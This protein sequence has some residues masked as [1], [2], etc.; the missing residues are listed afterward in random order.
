MEILGREG[1]DTT[2]PG[3]HNADLEASRTRVIEGATWKQQ[4]TIMLIPSA[5]TIPAQVALAL[6][7]L[8][9]PPN[10]GIV[11]WLALGLEVGD[12]YSQ[13]IEQILANP[14]LSKWE[15]LLTVEHD[16]LPPQDGL[17]KLIKRMEAHPEFACIGGLYWTK[18]EGGAPQIW[19]DI[20][21]PVQNYRPQPPVPGQLVEC[22]GTGMGFNLWRLS[23]FK[24]PKIAR[25]WF[26]TKC[27]PA[28][29]VGTQDL[30]FWGE[31]RKYGYRCA[32]DCDV[33]VGH[34]DATTGVVW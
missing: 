2:L 11:R 21:D 18:G 24:D 28:E 33:L 26:R 13:A 19:G 27:S 5:K 9:T 6:W 34:L 1:W 4:R 12:A 7:N 29:G 31:A 15:Y 3:R 16:N 20:R 22:W 23:M 30:A 17:L 25:P 14:E 32:V 10:Q 8:I